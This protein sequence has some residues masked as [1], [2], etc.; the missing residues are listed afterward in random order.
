MIFKAAPNNISVLYLQESCFDMTGA[1]VVYAPID[2]CSINAVLSG[3]D[4]GYMI[5]LPSGFAIL[6]NMRVS[7]GEEI[8]GTIL[9]LGFQ[10]LDNNSTE[11]YLPPE[12][13][14][15]VCSLIK[16]TVTS[17]KDAIV[18]PNHP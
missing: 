4:P 2:T 18:S 16:E 11:D 3:G 5:I 9:T 7:H 14:G 17:I 6:P 10:L 1:Y 8:G 15:T 12:S 13:V